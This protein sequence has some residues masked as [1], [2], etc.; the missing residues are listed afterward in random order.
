MALSTL[1]ENL[2]CICSFQ[3]ITFTSQ[4]H[5][6]I[7]IVLIL[8]VNMLVPGINILIYSSTP[9]TEVLKNLKKTEKSMVKIY[10]FVF[11]IPYLL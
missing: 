10:Y 7:Y 6:L 1:I 11:A 8:Q 9:T 4:E 2:A 5:N 3:T